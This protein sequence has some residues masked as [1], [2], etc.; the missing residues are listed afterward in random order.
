MANTFYLRIACNHLHLT[1]L[2]SAR[3][4]VLEADPPFSNQRLLVADFSIADR[5][6]AKTVQGLMP[7]RLT[8]L[9]AAPKLLIQP[10]ERLEGGL[11]QVEERILMELGMGAGARK[12]V[13]HVGEILDAAGVRSR[14]K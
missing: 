9:N 5:L 13:V 2:E 10:L 4:T 6:I 7:K 1:H 11:S 12:V 14:L 3:V 8:F